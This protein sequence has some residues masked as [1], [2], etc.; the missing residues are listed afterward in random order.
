MKVFDYFPLVVLLDDELHKPG[1]ST[2]KEK[3]NI[4]NK[5]SRSTT[6]TDDMISC[7]RVQCACSHCSPRNNTLNMRLKR[8][9]DTVH[10]KLASDGSDWNNKSKHK[11]LSKSGQGKNPEHSR[12]MLN[13]ACALSDIDHPDLQNDDDEC[14]TGC[15]VLW[16]NGK[17]NNGAQSA[18]PLVNHHH[19]HDDDDDTKDSKIQANNDTSN[20]QTKSR[21]TRVSRS[22]SNKQHASELLVPSLNSG[23]T[24]ST[25]N[26]PS[27]RKPLEV[28][29]NNYNMCRDC[30]ECECGSSSSLSAQGKTNTLGRTDGNTRLLPAFS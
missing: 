16:A 18:R 8:T 30:D 28:V 23:S 11:T 20:N 13:E 3:L 19:M 24:S 26:T 1:P 9:S 7:K 21:N 5:T 6:L 10:K 14:C 17:D 12:R 15:A 27:S 22:S 4:T 29:S 25:I 2:R